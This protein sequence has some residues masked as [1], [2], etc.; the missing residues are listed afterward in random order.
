M[1][2]VGTPYA[3]AQVD[4]PGGI[5][6]G[7]D[8]ADATGDSAVP[9]V[10]AADA[11]VAASDAV[12]A[13]IDAGKDSPSCP[14]ALVQA[15]YVK[16]SIKASSRASWTFFGTALAMDG[17]TMVVGAVGE[18]MLVGSVGAAYVFVHKAGLWAQQATLKPT[19]SACQ[20]GRQQRGH[21]R[22][23]LRLPAHGPVRRQQP[24]HE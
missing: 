22:R 6:P 3:A 8:A 17:D 23:G 7:A 14:A 5:G 19:N 11:A 24:V 18:S 21:Q 20:P 12:D 13:V 9:G 2:R 4:V 10:D 1:T 16:A 15:A